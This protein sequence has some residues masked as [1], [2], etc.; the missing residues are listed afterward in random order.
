MT[1]NDIIQ[2]AKQRFDQELHTPRYKKIHA[3]T[4]HLERLIERL[5][6]VKGISHAERFVEMS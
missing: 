6:K 3:D 4:E 2:M 5:K 1:E